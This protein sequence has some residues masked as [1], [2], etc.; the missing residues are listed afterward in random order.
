MV[1]KKILYVIFSINDNAVGGH[2]HS[3][4]TVI[5]SLK[6]EVQYE[7]LNIGVAKSPVLNGVENVTFISASKS[8]FFPSVSKISAFIKNCNPNVLHAFDNASLIYVNQACLF[9][10]TPIIFTKCG[11]EN[12]SIKIP[13]S[14]QYLFFSQENLEFYKKHSTYKN[15]NRWMPNRVNGKIRQ[16]NDRIQKL[17]NKYDLKDKK[18]MLRIARFGPLHEMSIIQS[19]N[20]LKLYK[21][22]IDNNIV[23]LIIGT[24]Q[25]E[26][27]YQRVKSLVNDQSIHVI[28]DDYYTHNASELINISDIVVATGRGVMEAS[29]LGNKIIFCPLANHDLPVAM[30]KN[31]FDKLFYYN[32]SS[33]IIGI[34]N[35]EDIIVNEVKNSEDTLIK[36]SKY[37]FDQYFDINS[38]KDEYLK[39]YSTIVSVKGNNFKFILNHLNILLSYF[40]VLKK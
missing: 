8:N 18:V 33:R 20:L 22:K 13:Y 21:E 34:K 28:S 40:G 25:S 31:N 17:V 30:N 10:K 36:F 23:L 24:V 32:F 39:L 19:I 37:A 26:E 6:G 1:V 7:V 3:L 5:N 29:S 16:D 2:F 27:I 12:G 11:G 38:I 9:D 4:L 15:R 35:N 14:D